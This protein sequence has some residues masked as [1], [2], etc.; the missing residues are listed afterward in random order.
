M[1]LSF[2][3]KCQENEGKLKTI[4]E[5]V[6]KSETIYQLLKASN[7]MMIN[8]MKYNDHGPIHAKIV[9]NHALRILEILFR[10]GFPPNVIKDYNF[11]LEDA[12]IVV[13]L[14]SVLHDVGNSVQ[15][16]QHPMISVILSK[17]EIRKVL[18]KA[19]GENEREVIL[20]ETLHAI[21]SH[22][23]LFPQTIEASIVKVADALDME[24]GRARIPYLLGKMSI[25]QVS[26][27]AVKKVTVNEGI[28]KPVY[29][30][31]EMDNPA[32]IF[33]IDELLLKRISSS[34]LSDK[35]ELKANIKGVGIFKIT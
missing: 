31:V 32:G 9:A 18:T 14:A 3:V 2:G 13:F 11:G 7:I 29:I 17:D 35:V 25:H 23:D 34:L 33:Q 21:V 16:E 27:L 8:R 22:E 6:E 4:I 10:K 24:E 28:T 19:Y 15:R 1:S 30:E 20:T 12:K 26:A 5:E